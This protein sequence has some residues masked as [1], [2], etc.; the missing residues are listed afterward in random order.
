[1]TKGYTI[2]HI[3]D[4]ETT[5]HEQPRRVSNFAQG[6]IYNVYPFAMLHLVF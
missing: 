2:T 3:R 1:M 4:K 5:L 6:F